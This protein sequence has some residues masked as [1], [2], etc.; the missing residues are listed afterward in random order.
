MRKQILSGLLLVL[1]GA[2]AQAKDK[3]TVELFVM[4]KCPFCVQVEKD[5]EAVV[6]AMGDAVVFSLDF[7]GSEKEGKLTALHGEAEV[8][9]NLIQICAKRHHPHNYMRL[10]HCM[11]ENQRQIPEGWEQCANRAGVSIEAIQA[12]AQ[13]QEGENLLRESYRRSKAKKALGTPTILI[14]GTPHRGTRGEQAYIRVICGEFSGR[15]PEVCKNVPEPVV[16]PIIILTDSRCKECRPEFWERAFTGM[17]PGAKVKVVDYVTKVGRRLYKKLGPVKLPVV[18]FG[19]AVEK[20]EGYARLKHRMEPKGK[21]LMLKTYGKWDP[22]KEICDNRKDDNG[23]GLIDCQD[24][25]C[26]HSLACREATPKKLEVFIMSQCPYAVRGLNAMKEV[27]RQFDNDIKFEIHF[28]AE[29]QG[30]GFKALHGQ[31]EVEEN[32]R[33]LCVI[34][35]Y[36]DAF[37]F[38]D[39]IW[40]RNENVRSGDWTPCTGNNG[41][42][43]TMIDL[44][45]TGGEGKDLLREDIKIAQGLGIQGSPTWVVNGRHKFNGIDVKVIVENFCKHNKEFWGCREGG[46]R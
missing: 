19:K 23:D 35:Y 45:Y 33:E 5:L 44:C 14:N 31:P 6:R 7:V 24:A 25:T 18:L 40:C 27:L 4:S 2:S 32:I 34:K 8:K 37:K 36:P 15:K 38:M 13:G 12:C 28:I 3:V 39:Y 46:R 42:D 22:T 26:K 9:G 17:F 29:E 20:A 1:L 30:E 41:I 11:N 10:I 21:Y 43:T 16:V